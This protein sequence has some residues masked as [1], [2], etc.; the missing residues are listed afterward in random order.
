MVCI[1]DPACELLP[2]GRRNYILYL[3]T[4]AP[5]L[6][7]LS[8]LL[9]PPPLPNV[10]YIQTVCGCGGGWGG[11][12]MYC[13]PY[14]AG[15][16]TLF[17]TR[18]RTYKIATPPQTKMTRKGDIKGF[19]S[20]K[21]LRLCCRGFNS[22]YVG[23]RVDTKHFVIKCTMNIHCEYTSNK[24]SAGEDPL[25]CECRSRFSKSLVTLDTAALSRT[26][27]RMYFLAE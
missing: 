6:Y 15:V 17:L 8:D 12:E 22:V 25:C 1:F 23:Q 3:C 21:L 26:K 13:G 2:Q 24:H 10:Q 20:L 19:V 4:V 5:L 27:K 14:S 7:L 11:V 16:S 9:P 18:F